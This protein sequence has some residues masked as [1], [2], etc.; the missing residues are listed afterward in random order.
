LIIVFRRRGTRSRDRIQ[1]EMEDLFHSMSVAGR[2]LQ[3]RS[4]HVH[5]TAW[6]PPLDVYATA[7]AL[8]VVAELA[9]VDEENIQVAVDDAVLSI[10]GVR[11]AVCDEAQRSVHE[12]GILHGPFAADIYLPFAVDHDAAEA[13]YDRGLLQVRLPR[14][15]GTRIAISAPD[16]DEPDR[17]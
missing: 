11:E 3:L 9:G 15:A 17:A 5:A 8:I 14:E 13:T 10:R 6:R 1:S 12:M 4:P 16:T 2:P 7:D